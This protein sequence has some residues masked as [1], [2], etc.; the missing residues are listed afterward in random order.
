MLQPPE[1]HRDA[2]AILHLGAD[3][4]HRYGVKEK[5]LYT[6]NTDAKRGEL[7]RHLQTRI[8]E[9]YKSVLQMQMQAVCQ[10]ARSDAHQY[11]RDIFKA[12]DW[13][14]MR[15]TVHGKDNDYE[16]LEKALDES[17]NRD[18]LHAARRL[19]VSSKLDV[20]QGADYY[21]APDGYEARRSCYPGTREALLALVWQWA[22]A[23]DGPPI[24]WLHGLAGTGKS[25][26][27]RTVAEHLHDDREYSVAS[28]FFR[29][30]HHE[31]ASVA[32]LLSTLADQLAH[33]DN[34]FCQALDEA[35]TKYP[36]L[37][38]SA[39]LA[40]QYRQ[41][42]L[43]PL[44]GRCRA[45]SRV[46]TLILVLDALDECENR[47]D[48][49]SVLRL[50]SDT[51]N[52]ENLRVRI[53]LT[54][55][56][57]PELI[58][59]FAHIPS[60]RKQELTLQDEKD[61]NQDI[62]FYLRERL[63]HIQKDRSL[64]I[65]WPTAE[66]IYTVASKASGLFIFAETVCRYVDVD[67]REEPCGRLD[68]LCNDHLAGSA[69]YAPL[70]SMYQRILTRSLEGLTS[71]EH[72]RRSEEQRRVVGCIIMLFSPLPLAAIENLLI[73]IQP[74]EGRVAQAISYLQS[75]FSIPI[76]PHRPVSIIH[77]SF[78]D[79]LIHPERA[80]TNPKLFVSEAE[81]HGKLLHSCLTLM[82]A[83]LKRNLCAL[84][85]PGANL[86]ELSDATLSAVLPPSLSYACRFWMRH[87]SLAN[88]QADD[89]KSIY[90]F[91]S[92]HFLHWVECM[93]V[94]H[95][96]SDSISELVLMQGKLEVR[97]VGLFNNVS[98]TLRTH[99]SSS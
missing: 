10:F 52:L 83:S 80:G 91:M 14:A 26:I 28:F 84:P 85:F 99:S 42:V 87:A 63:S 88:L 90:D 19:R 3:V 25:T 36:T 8:V 51:K 65:H 16:K 64:P 70:D 95:S 73:H 53:F 76:D 6:S 79:Y 56:E 67:R 9:L 61:V 48:I 34:H 59:D 68:D 94:L 82:T 44:E 75:V 71:K 41:L 17:T 60:V 97:T 39:E 5:R 7:L 11:V 24:F 37:G 55:R 33:R 20:A 23:V 78:R 1:Q 96:M 35:L 49:R 93:S 29:R 54:S 13:A 58:A 72:K 47:A 15:K 43:S 89:V 77:Q 86:E 12:D 32:K 18:E 30:D 21:S 27:A 57:E 74:G 50:I 62:T 69:A 81:T 40:K 2:I 4:I 31:L 45:A 92:L 38:K 46:S 98:S 22:E 66:Q